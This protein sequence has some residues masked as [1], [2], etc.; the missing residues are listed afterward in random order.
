MEIFFDQNSIVIDNFPL[1]VYDRFS[2]IK[3][4]NLFEEEFIINLYES[5]HR[6]KIVFHS[7][8]ELSIEAV[9]QFIANFFNL[10]VRINLNFTEAF[11][12]SYDI[13]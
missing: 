7:K 5:S 3:L 4:L 9:H 6:V 8:E 10:L 2:L 1:A 13:Q 12:D 11:I